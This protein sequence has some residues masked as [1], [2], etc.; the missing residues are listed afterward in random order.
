MYD[1][2]TSMNHTP[3]WF[4]KHR[5]IHTFR[6]LIRLFYYQILTKKRRPTSQPDTNKFHF[7]LSREIPSRSSG[8]PNAMTS[9]GFLAAYRLFGASYMAALACVHYIS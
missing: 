5:H 3:T 2:L 6:E 9:L 1:V 7:L 8:A 4:Y